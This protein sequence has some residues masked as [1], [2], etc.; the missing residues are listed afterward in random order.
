M[1]EGGLVQRAYA[2]LP[3]WAQNATISTYGVYWHWLRFGHG[4]E[5]SVREF[6]RRERFDTKTWDEWERN[7]LRE[8]LRQ[9]SE[10]VPYYRRT[11]TA[12][13]KRAA[14]SGEL[15]ELP[16]LEK[17]PLR[18]DPDDFV[19]DDVR[20]WPRFTHLTSGSTGTPIAAISTIQEMRASRALREVRSVR[21]A[22]TSFTEPRSTF[23]GRIV[24]PDPHSRGPFYRYN[25][26]ERQVYFSAFHLSAETAPKYV[27]A[28]RRHRIRWLT[29]YAVSYY[30]LARHILDQNLEVPPLAAVIPTSEKV[31]PAM[32]EVMREAY[33][34]RVFEEYSTVE[35]AL[36]ASECE[37]GR[38]HVS[39]D[40]AK[41]EILR[42]DGSPCDPGEP[43]EV[44][45]T[46]FLRRLQPLVRFRLGDTAAWSHES[47][48][49]GRALPILQEVL[50]RTEDV[51]V[52]SDGRETVRF[53]GIFVGLPHV[54]EAQ[55]IQ[56]A[57]S[58]IRLD[59]V[60]AAGYG[61]SDEEEMIRRVQQRLGPETRVE[62]V[63]V[64][65]IPRGPG[66]KFQAV[67]SRVS[68]TSTTE[69]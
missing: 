15:A 7:E 57:I 25:S 14:R 62:V 6:E 64:D 53:H 60:V 51:V 40:V 24:E 45:T 4:F 49:C 69:R 19:R 65:S 3:L 46:A 27:E 22:G 1:G 10:H 59:V 33:R 9:A 16:L 37:E 63:P 32:R 50:G 52:G 12:A 21:W 2:A 36:F 5:A 56:E 26:V 58:E 41:V 8:V 34:C 43:G 61:P 39:P 38:L 48:P 11:W 47:C 29:G 31:T 68:R 44:V 30:L 67:V 23:S 42:P 17:S 18:A 20:A 55:V 28:L 13:Q 54:I 35:Q 66:G